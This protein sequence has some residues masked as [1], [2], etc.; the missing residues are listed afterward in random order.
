[1][2]EHERT[3]TFR[4]GSW[5]V[6]VEPGPWFGKTGDLMP[7]PRGQRDKADWIVIVTAGGVG[8][9]FFESGLMQDPRVWT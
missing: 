5:V 8:V 6:V 2:A 3:N 9:G 1:M 4:Q 7:V